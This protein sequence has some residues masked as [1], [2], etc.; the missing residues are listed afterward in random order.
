[1]GRLDFYLP[2]QEVNLG[3]RTQP[4]YRIIWG[5]GRGRESKG[6][7]KKRERGFPFAFYSNNK[8]VIDSVAR[9]VA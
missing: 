8:T 6:E 1:M 7:R 5:R 9:P 3:I 4:T 2:G